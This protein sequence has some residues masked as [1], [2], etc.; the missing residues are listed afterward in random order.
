M[1]Y[2]TP[3]SVLERI[4]DAIA[5]LNLPNEYACMVVR[6]F[7]AFLRYGK[8][9]KLTMFQIFRWSGW[10]GQEI[11]DLLF[12]DYGIRISLRAFD[13]ENLYFCIFDTSEKKH[14]AA[15][16][17]YILRREGV[18]L[19]TVIDPSSFAAEELGSMPDK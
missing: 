3:Y 7:L 1:E 15:W 12:E 10:S 18:P 16:A 8:F 6:Q 19:L 4:T 17:E 5:C 14:V 2:Q 9:A 13:R 11:E